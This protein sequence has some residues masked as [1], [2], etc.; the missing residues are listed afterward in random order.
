MYP[1]TDKIYSCIKDLR[2]LRNYYCD[3][4]AEPE[5]VEYE[6]IDL[7]QSIEDE[8]D[9]NIGY[10][11]KM[12][13]TLSNKKNI[14]RD[15]LKSITNEASEVLEEFIDLLE[16][17]TTAFIASSIYKDIKFKSTNLS[18]RFNNLLKVF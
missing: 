5:I 15:S 14:S 1:L 12:L 6:Y 18:K 3:S 2:E 8:L 4:L 11:D 7:L 10:L 16:N 13:N 17:N 9:Y